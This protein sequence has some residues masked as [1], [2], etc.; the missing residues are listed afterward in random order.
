VT[1]TSAV[2]RTQ[3]LVR[4]ARLAGAVLIAGLVVL[5]LAAAASAEAPAAA[6]VGA[7]V[8][9]TWPL[10]VPQATPT[11]EIPLESAPP[12]PIPIAHP[13]DASSTGCVDCHAQVDQKQEAIAEDWRASIHAREGVGCADCH[14]GDPRS[15][16]ITVGMAERNGYLGVPGRDETVGLCGGCHA[17][18]ERMRPY[19][20]AT[21]QY[22]KYYSSVHG[23]R[24]LVGNDTR[25]A[26][27]VDCHG[28]HAVKPASDPTADV[29]PLNVPKL[30]ASCHADA[31]TMQPYGIPTDQFDIYKESVHGRQLLDEQDLRAPTCASCHGSHAAKPPRSDEVV[32]VCGKCHTATQALYEESAHSRVPAVGPKCWTCHG[33]HDVSEPD[34]RLFLHEGGVPDYLCATCHSPVDQ[35]L[36]LEIDRFEDPADRRC[37]TCHHGRSLIFTQV[38]AIATAIGGANDGY[39]TALRRIEEAA[40]LGMIVADA[41]VAAAE[42]RTGLIR[43]RAAVHTTKL[44]TISALTDETVEKARAAE[45]IAR[46]KLSESDFRRQAMIVVIAIIILNVLVLMQIRRRLHAG[47]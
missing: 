22:S 7:P 8:G 14:G 26:I 37:D 29:Y 3:G 45:E 17:N 4:L 11:P 2:T 15:D 1:R 43:A 6:P 41:E 44:A 30:C 47:T 24:L 5:F 19:Q 32:D 42:A 9:A 23:Q 40:S 25:V 36:R 16:E 13:G 46:A 39:E 28:S 21:D 34:E 31:D 38:E 10:S 27:C 18:A 12:V 35:S 20:V 33:T